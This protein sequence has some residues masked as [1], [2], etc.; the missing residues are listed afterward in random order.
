MV[1]G[2]NCMSNMSS[3]SKFVLYLTYVLKWNIPIY[4]YNLQ[5][6]I[7]KFI[8]DWHYITPTPCN[9][10]LPQ[11]KYSSDSEIFIYHITFIEVAHQQHKHA[12]NISPQVQL[13]TSQKQLWGKTVLNMPSWHLRILIN[14]YLSELLVY[15][16]WK[17]NQWNRIVRVITSRWIISLVT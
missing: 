3:I 11:Y 10:T 8:P 15:S 5:L 9:Q 7:L 16:D 4:S 2:T 6:M 1:K 13:K 12:C 17:S 14:S